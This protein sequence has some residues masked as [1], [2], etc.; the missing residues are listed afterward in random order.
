MHSDNYSYPYL[1]YPCIFLYAIFF[2][3]G[4]VT[5]KAGCLEENC[6]VNCPVVVIAQIINPDV[7]TLDI[8][9]KM[10]IQFT[11]T[12]YVDCVV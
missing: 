8:G 10:G 11:C 9:Q 6:M 2:V 12:H 7:L 4:N 5:W 1:H 3:L